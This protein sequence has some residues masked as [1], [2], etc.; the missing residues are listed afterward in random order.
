MQVLSARYGVPTPSQNPLSPL[1]QLKSDM[2]QAVQLT[3]ALE[4]CTTPYLPQKAL[5]VEMQMA[6]ILAQMEVDG[7]GKPCTIPHAVSQLA[8]TP[9]SKLRCSKITLVD[10]TII[11]VC[12]VAEQVSF[13]RSFDLI[14]RVFVR[15]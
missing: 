6:V 12:A 2:L 7:M 10:D 4:G 1:Q 13:V 14:C 3:A 5:R 15:S 9:F 8:A 11:A